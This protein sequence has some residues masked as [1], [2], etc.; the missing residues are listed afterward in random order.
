M[1]STFIH[2]VADDRISFFMWL[3]NITY[4]HMQT[5]HILFI[6]I[7]KAWRTPKCLH[8]FNICKV[9]LFATLASPRSILSQLKDLNFPSNS[10]TYSHSS[11]LYT[12]IIYNYI[13]FTMLTYI[14]L[15]LSILYSMH[16]LISLSNLLL[17][18]LFSPSAYSIPQSIDP[19]NISVSV[20]PNIFSTASLCELDYTFY[21][22][23]HLLHTPLNRSLSPLLSYPGQGSILL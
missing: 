3:C 1:H 7:A 9:Y 13:I 6:T 23:N 20:I 18:V 12:T 2:A 5:Y 19:T 22:Y 10:T 16:S 21:F 15:M 8:Y 14:I 4:I 11:M 17:V